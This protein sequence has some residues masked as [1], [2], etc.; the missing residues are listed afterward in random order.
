ML[1]NASALTCILH[2]MPEPAGAQACH[3]QVLTQT[4]RALAGSMM[5]LGDTAAVATC[6][7]NLPGFIAGLAGCTADTNT[8]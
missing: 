3:G 2:G 8:L 7:A 4:G 1:Q 6:F 5:V